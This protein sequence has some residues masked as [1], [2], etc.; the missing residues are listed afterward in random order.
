M[1]TCGCVGQRVILFALI[2]VTYLL[3][4]AVAQHVRDA[5]KANIS[6]SINLKKYNFPSFRIH[7]SLVPR[8][9]NL[10]TEMSV[11]VGFRLVSSLCALLEPH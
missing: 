4:Q 3:L 6:S 2:N 1:F 7:S 5:S 11:P 9:L 8:I 10:G